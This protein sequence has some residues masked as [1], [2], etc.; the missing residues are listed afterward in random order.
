[1]LEA[2]K[3][4]GQ[5]AARPGGPGISVKARRSRDARMALL[6][7]VSLGLVFLL[8]VVVGRGTLGGVAQA[9]GDEDRGEAAMD[10]TEEPYTQEAGSQTEASQESSAPAPQVGEAALFD[11]R[12]KYT[13][14]AISV[15]PANE[16]VA[17]DNFDHLKTQGLPV[18]RPFASPN[19][20]RVVVVGAAPK[21]SDLREIRSR[22]QRL[23]G[24]D[25]KGRP[26]EGAYAYPIKKLTNQAGD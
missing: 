8:G 26:Y 2:F 7:F 6:T 21:E 14:V 23:A 18:F 17:W 3:D 24:P 1:M 16:K 19:G 4:A 25:G 20:M 10:V 12:N 22:L 15:T 13:I 11:D 9:G 5:G